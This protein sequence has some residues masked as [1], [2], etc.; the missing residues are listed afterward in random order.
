MAIGGA[1]TTW[2]HATHGSPSSNTDYTAKT[3]SVNPT[4]DGE[5]V[6]ATTFGDSFRES[7]QTFKSFAFTV[8]YKYDS[9][10]WA[11]I[12]DLWTNGTSITFELGPV[13]VTPPNPKITGSM[14]C[15]SFSEPFNVGELQV[16]EVSFK[17]TGAPSFGAFS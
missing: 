10:I 12:G 6:D 4:F 11:V 5:E 1:A 3:M 17:G 8:R 2:K 14:Y 7:E 9:T 13:G 16:M 15:Q